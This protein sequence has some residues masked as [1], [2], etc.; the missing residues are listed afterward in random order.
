MKMRDRILSTSL[1]LFNAEGVTGLSALEIATALG[2]SPGN[3]YYH[4]KGKKEIVAALFAA[5]ETELG[6]VIEAASLD[7][8]R[9]D[10]GL[11]ALQTHIHILLEEANDVRFLYRESGALLVQ[12]PELAPR[13]QRVVIAQSVCVSHML[14]CLARRGL[15]CSEPAR[16]E[17]LSRQIILGVCF[18]LNQLELEQSGVSPRKSVARATTDIMNM[19][20]AFAPGAS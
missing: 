17:T 3:L 10:A 4:F 11:H 5:Y 18:A 1:S 8:L 15:I 7:L 14:S 20:A 16:L 6:L 9:D 12:M 2:I 13:F 19:V